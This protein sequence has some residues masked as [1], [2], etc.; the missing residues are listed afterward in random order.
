MVTRLGCDCDGVLGDFNSLGLHHLNTLLGTAYTAEDLTRFD[1]S[2][3][4]PHESVQRAEFRRRLDA[5]DALLDIPAYPHASALL[6]GLGRLGEVW[7]VTSPMHNNQTWCAQRL[8][9][10]QERLGVDRH[11][12]AF[13]SDKSAFDGAV[14]IDD[15]AGNLHQF[16]DG[17]ND[18]RGILWRQPYSEDGGRVPWNGWWTTSVDGALAAVDAELHARESWPESAHHHDFGARRFG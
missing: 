5:S 13:M 3:L 12:V 2:D 1:F 6:D 9:W 11:R 17:G 14:L 8:R 4:I 10:L 16:E 18:R 15:Y 7:V